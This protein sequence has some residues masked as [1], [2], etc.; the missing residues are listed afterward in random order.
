MP[1]DWV[2]GRIRIGGGVEPGCS[3]WVLY[4]WIFSKCTWIANSP[5]DFPLTLFNLSSNPNSSLWIF[6]C[7]AE[8]ESVSVLRLS[9]AAGIDVIFSLYFIVFQIDFKLSLVSTSKFV[10]KW[11]KKVR[12]LNRIKFHGHRQPILFTQK[13]DRSSWRQSISRWC[14]RHC[15]HE[16]GILKYWKQVGGGIQ[17]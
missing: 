13:C 2:V 11:K 15:F 6:P 8:D 14:R 3:S 12:C 9:L 17:L 1:L 16:L 4:L 5:T 10:K 7:Q